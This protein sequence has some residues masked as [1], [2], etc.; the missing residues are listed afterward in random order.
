MDLL[1]NVEKFFSVSI[2]AR[3]YFNLLS[4]CRVNN[5]NNIRQTPLHVAVSLQNC[6]LLKLLLRAAA[7]PNMFFYKWLNTITLCYPFK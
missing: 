3:K 7:N 5:Q 4:G 6:A 1:A 2:E